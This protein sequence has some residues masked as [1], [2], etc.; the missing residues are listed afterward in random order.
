MKYLTYDNKN[1]KSIVFIHGMATTALQ[2][3]ELILPYLKDYYIVLVEVDGHILEDHSLLTSFSNAC[4]EIESYIREE[5]NNE[6]YCLAGFSMGA[7]MAVEIASRNHIQITKLFLDATFL[8]DMGPIL[9]KLYTFVF[10]FFIDWIKK[11]NTVPDLLLDSF[12][13]KGNKS[14]IE[15]LYYGV[16]RDT[17]KNVCQYVYSY[18][19]KEEIKDYK[20]EALFIYG[21]NEP[22]PRKGAKLLASY[23]PKLKQK[24]IPNMGHG[25]FLH[26]QAKDYSKV[27]LEFLK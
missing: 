11:G 17:I 25:Q 27:L 4:K 22:Y 16:E 1:N 12:M 10:C 2:C 7:T 9:S 23:L 14:I 6:V 13:G 20:G 21:S 26:T 8:V 18:S 3:Y 19:I 15:M 24:E 5:Q